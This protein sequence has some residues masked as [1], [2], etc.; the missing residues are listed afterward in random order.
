MTDSVY[1]DE[2]VVLLDAQNQPVGTKEK[3]SAHESCTSRHLAFSVWLFNPKGQCLITRRSLTKKAWPGIWTNS[4]CGHPQW[5]ESIEEAI[6]R[7]CRYEIGVDVRAVTLIDRNFS[8]C[9]TDLGGI[10]E[11]EYCPV[12]AA[13]TND[14]I[15]PRK[16][17]VI[18][19]YWADLMSI[20]TTIHSIPS[21]F[22][23]W[24]V[25][26]VN[27]P[28]NTARLNDYALNVIHLNFPGS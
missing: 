16:D 15:A 7:R 23:P 24:S 11:N 20:I 25:Q 4:V 9:E 14:A 12:Y 18:D 2:H 21:L 3:L 6:H 13:L 17:E 28:G 26:Q 22:S 27:A 8:Y 5:N 19:I 1:S 10:R